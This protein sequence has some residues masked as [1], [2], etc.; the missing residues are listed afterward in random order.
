MKKKLIALILAGICATP[1]FAQAATTPYVS[2]NCGLG[3][4]QSTNVS[5]GSD[6]YNGAISYKTG[7]LLTDGPIGGAVGLKSDFYRVEAAVGYQQFSADTITGMTVDRSDKVSI[8]TYM[9]NAYFDDEM[10]GSNLIP[11]IMG[12]IGAATVKPQGTNLAGSSESVFAWQVGAGIGLKATNNLVV[13]LGY[14]FVNPSPYQVT[15]PA[16]GNAEFTAGTSNILLGMRYN[17]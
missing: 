3:F 6:T 13:D 12:G 10:K 8:W 15:V 14:R 11:Y 9:V 17:F 1:T 7:G 5:V 4:A 2:A 16:Y